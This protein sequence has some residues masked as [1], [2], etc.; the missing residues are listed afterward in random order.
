[1]VSASPASATHGDNLHWKGSGLRQVAVID[2]TGNSGFH[3]AVVG[4][5]NN[6]NSGLHNV[7]LNLTTSSGAC[8][9]SGG[10]IQVCL[11]KR[12]GGLARWTNDSAN[13]FFGVAVRLDR[14][15][16]TYAAALAC[17]ELGHA[18]GLA[19]RLQSEQ[20]T[21]CMSPAVGA[22]QTHPDAH[23]FATVDAQTNHTD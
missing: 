17:H 10:N 21:T 3:S 4:A 11:S 2:K 8:S 1:M 20:N 18:L 12:V 16:P 19:H 23:D 22:G 6:W 9:S 13:H 7:H 15:H 5:V 14:Y